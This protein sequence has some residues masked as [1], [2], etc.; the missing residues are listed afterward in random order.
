MWLGKGLGLSG[1][2]YPTP[3]WY[4]AYRLPPMPRPQHTCL[5]NTNRSQGIAPNPFK[6]KISL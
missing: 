2:L 6:G 4:D 3:K 1:P 5:L